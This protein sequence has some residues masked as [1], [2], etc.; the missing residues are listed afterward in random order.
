MSNRILRRAATTRDFPAQKAPAEILIAEIRKPVLA[1][2]C[3]GTHHRLTPEC[4]FDILL[5]SNSAPS[6]DSPDNPREHQTEQI[7][8]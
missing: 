1:S 2:R 7:H 3:Y 5:R 4:R 6:A 8:A